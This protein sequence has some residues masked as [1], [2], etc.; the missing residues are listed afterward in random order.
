MLAGKLLLGADN[1]PERTERWQ[2]LIGAW[3]GQECAMESCA[4]QAAI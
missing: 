2:L 3:T 4:G 1:A